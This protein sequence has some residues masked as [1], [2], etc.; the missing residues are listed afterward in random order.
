MIFNFAVSLIDKV[1][2]CNQLFL[3]RNSRLFE[4][5]VVLTFLKEEENRIAVV[6]EV[7]K[8]FYG[9][10]LNFFCISVFNNF[11]E[12]FFAQDC[13]EKFDVLINPVRQKFYLVEEVCLETCIFCVFE[14]SVHF[15]RIVNVAVELFKSVVE[16]NCQRRHNCAYFL[17]NKVRSYNLLVCLMRAFYKALEVVVHVHEE[18]AVFISLFVFEKS[19]ENVCAWSELLFS[20]EFVAEFFFCRNFSVTNNVFVDVVWI[21]TKN[22]V[23]FESFLCGCV[24]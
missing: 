5:C 17:N 22:R 21:Y 8:Y 19:H 14:K 11:V 7:F 16:L 9:K 23:C 24:P 1:Y 4:P 12:H 20:L 18:F 15:A 13:R 2:D 10:F 6:A 3:I